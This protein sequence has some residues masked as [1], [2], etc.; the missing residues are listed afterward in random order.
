MAEDNAAHSEESCGSRPAPGRPP[1]SPGNVPPD[2]SD[3]VSLRPWLTS[4]RL[5]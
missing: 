3:F 1:L 2:K 5:C 4:G